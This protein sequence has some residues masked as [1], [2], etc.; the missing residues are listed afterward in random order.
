[1]GGNLISL[2]SYILLQGWH[3]GLLYQLLPLSSVYGSPQCQAH[4]FFI[5]WHWP[6]H[7]MQLSSGI[8]SKQQCLH[9]I[10]LYGSFT[11]GLR[12]MVE[13]SLSSDKNNWKSHTE[14]HFLKMS[15]YKQNYHKIQQ[16]HFWVFTWRRWNHSL[17][18]I[19]A[20]LCSFT[21]AKTWKQP[22]SNSRWMN[23]ENDSFHC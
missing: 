7:G 6:R 11:G 15:L 12:R 3:S 19:Y 18:K 20:P 17:E 22:V 8:L 16:F 13:V 5:L 14:H 10:L 23:E 4:M 2:N 21:I 9:N 1:M